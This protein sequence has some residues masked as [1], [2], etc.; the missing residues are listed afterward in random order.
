MAIGAQFAGLDMKNLIG[1]PLAA[2]AEA[3]LNLAQTTANFINTVGFNADKSTRTVLFQF[4]KSDADALGNPIR[5][6]MQMEIPMLAIV[7]I[8]NLQIDEVNIVF[9]MEVKE[10]E[11]SENSLDAGGSFSASLKIGPFNASISGSV[12]SHSSNTRSSDN[13]AKYHVD[14]RATN[15]GY[16]EGL[17]RVMDIMA[18]NA[19]P[20]LLASKMVDENGKEVDAASKEK[21]AKLQLS[22]ETQQKL[23]TACKAASDEYETAIKGVRDSVASFRNAQKLK[24]QKRLNT[25]DSITD[26]D[27]DAYTGRMQ[28]I[29][30][31]WDRVEADARMT[32]ESLY[33]GSGGAQGTEGQ[34]QRVDMATLFEIKKIKDDVSGIE[35]V[36]STEITPI[37][38]YFDKAVNN[39]ATFK[40]Q[41]KALADERG[42]YN[43]LLVKR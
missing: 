39:Y 34:A 29:I 4:Q 11:K 36:A 19:A 18:A 8:P 14:V 37:Q 27:R 15:H 28:E 33:G 10:T 43:A 22:Y 13:S 38:N 41:E 30:S 35:A 17:A 23:G 2:S 25:G 5:S 42:N 16:P 24:V 31:I 40:S 9:D 3:S 21:R 6:E 26:A 12:S 32:V 7:P 1:G 20:T